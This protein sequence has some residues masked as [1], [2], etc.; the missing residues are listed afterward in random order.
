MQLTQLSSTRD[1]VTAD[2]GTEE[3]EEDEEDEEEEEEEEYEKEEEEYEKEDSIRP[4]KKEYALCLPL[5]NLLGR[6][7]MDEG[8]EV[9]CMR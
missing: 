1:D 9:Q 2:A 3:E 4:K 5:R 6:Q 8:K 7:T